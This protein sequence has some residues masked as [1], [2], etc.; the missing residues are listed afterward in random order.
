[1]D[2]LYR[3]KAPSYQGTGHASTTKQSAGFLG[4]IWCLFV[5]LFKGQVPAYRDRAGN[6]QVRSCG[7]PP[8]HTP[9]PVTPA[10]SWD[11]PVIVPAGDDDGCE[12]EP[13][14]EG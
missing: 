2:N 9:P 1:M 10:D 4:G 6:H 14:V 13:H 12:C 5:G 8:Y 11:P 7:T 3:T